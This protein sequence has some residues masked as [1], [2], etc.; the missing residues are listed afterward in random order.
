MTFRRGGETS[1]DQS[2]FCLAYTGVWWRKG[3]NLRSRWSGL[4]NRNLLRV[5]F[6]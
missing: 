3:R 2:P 4:I 1:D 6:I 5:R